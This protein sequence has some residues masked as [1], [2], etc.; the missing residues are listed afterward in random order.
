MAFT[1][2]QTGYESNFAAA[3]DDHILRVTILQNPS[4]PQQVATGFMLV[5]PT[6]GGAVK[7]DS[8]RLIFDQ[9]PTSPRAE[10]SDQG[11]SA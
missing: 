10:L 3:C 8:Q 11:G 2:R 1:A 9:L 6:S 4:N 7:V 5:T